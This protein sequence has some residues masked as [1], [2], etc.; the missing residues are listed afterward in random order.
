MS[1]IFLRCTVSDQ[2]EQQCG[3][4]SFHPILR[5]WYLMSVGSAEYTEV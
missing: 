2:A 3:A 1:I 5:L 4:V